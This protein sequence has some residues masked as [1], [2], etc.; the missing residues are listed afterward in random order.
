MI[1]IS[2]ENTVAFQGKTWKR[3]CVK[4][5]K[6][7]ILKRSTNAVLCIFVDHLLV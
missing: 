6:L 1:L 5:Q 2:N 3:D 7:A 4:L